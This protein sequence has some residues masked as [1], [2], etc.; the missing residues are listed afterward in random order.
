MIKLKLQL[1]NYFSSF[2]TIKTHNP[3]FLALKKSSTQRKAFSKTLKISTKH[4]S[5]R[6]RTSSSKVSLPTET[7]VHLYIQP[8]KSSRP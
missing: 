2:S 1:R 8:Y 7:K 4:A 5:F 6:Q 3:S